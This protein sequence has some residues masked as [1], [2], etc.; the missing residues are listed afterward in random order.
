MQPYFFVP[1]T[2]LHKIPSVL[3]M[4]VYKI[5]IDLEDAVSFSDTHKVLEDLLLKPELSE[6]FVRVPVINVY[7]SQIDTSIL[8]KLKS[9]GFGNFMLPKLRSFQQF[10][11]L[12]EEIDFAP[13]S[14]VL[15]IEN[16]SILYE[17]PLILKKYKHLFHG[18]CMGSHDYIAETGALYNMANLEYPRQLILNHAR[19]AEVSAIDIAS[20]E[21][22]NMEDFMVEVF[23]GFNKGYDA[24]LLIHPNQL[25]IFNQIEF[26]N[27]QEYDWAK[28]VLIE[29]SAIGGIE[30][31]RP[32][33]IDG[34]V[35]ERPHLKRAE[36]IENWFKKK[37][38]LP[39]IS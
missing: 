15:L 11:S 23:D 1:A 30:F 36:K 17:L 29:L 21:I 6:H 24:K 12:S 9:A 10:Q 4:G 3:E 5:I 19:M 26:Y 31:F 7:T 16:P 27:T 25:R 20:M 35:V 28:K 38:I 22:R 2:K 8:R 37:V 34:S 39:R 32:V 13:N 33:V 18:I 14:L